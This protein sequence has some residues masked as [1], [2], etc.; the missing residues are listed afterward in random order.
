MEIFTMIMISIAMSALSYLIAPKAGSGKSSYADME[1]PTAEA[2]RCIPVV[3]GTV[4][5][6]SG[7]FLWTGDKQKHVHT[8]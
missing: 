5:L 2:D 8:A 3:F 6:K 1:S 4:T 7:N